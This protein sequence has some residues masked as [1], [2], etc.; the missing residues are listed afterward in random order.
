VDQAVRLIASMKFPTDLKLDPKDIEERGTLRDDAVH[1]IR[2]RVGILPRPG[3][4]KRE[5][6]KTGNDAAAVLEHPFGPVGR[7]VIW[8]K[9]SRIG[10]RCHHLSSAR[11]PTRA[12][13]F[14]M[15][16]KARGGTL[17]RRASS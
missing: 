5:R 15:I 17:Q 6:S 2:S 3:F 13:F 14:A 1:K 4:S 16:R 7:G 8:A 11:P 12:A 10:K 9:D